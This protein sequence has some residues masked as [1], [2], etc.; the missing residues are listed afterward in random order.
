MGGVGS[1][2]YLA[3]E[4]YKQ[5]VFDE[6]SAVYG[7]GMLA[8]FLLNGLLPPLWNEYGEKSLECRMQGYRL[9]PP[10]LIKSHTFGCFKHSMGCVISQALSFESRYRFHSLSD[11]EEAIKKCMSLAKDDDEL[12][13]DG[14]SCER[15]FVLDKPDWDE[16]GLAR[17]NHELDGKTDISRRIYDFAAT[18]IGPEF[19][20]T[21]TTYQPK[22]DYVQTQPATPK[23]SFWS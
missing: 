6:T 19:D 22:Y 3:P 10:T 7:V 15:L 23:Q 18:A 14:G 8:Y 12:L 21:P 16:K 5:G 9:P 17:F 11:L 4:T 13:I 1:P 20:E 2:W